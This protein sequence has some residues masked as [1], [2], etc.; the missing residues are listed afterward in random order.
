MGTT[1]VNRHNH[2]TVGIAICTIIHLQTLMTIQPMRI[3]LI[4]INSVICKLS[5]IIEMENSQ[6]FKNKHQILLTK[7]TYYQKSIRM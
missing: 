7:L 4:S 6:A 5:L 1:I 3:Y 2:H